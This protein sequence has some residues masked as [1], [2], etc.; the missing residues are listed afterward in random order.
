M[1][2]S[3]GSPAV[4]S[5]L[6]SRLAALWAPGSGGPVCAGGAVWA[7]P[8]GAVCPLAGAAGDAGCSAAGGAEKAPGGPPDAAAAA[9]GAVARVQ[10][11][12][13]AKAPVRIWSAP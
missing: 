12:A 13:A 10:K 6:P 4:S 11:A 7:V 9:A 1:G 8:G 3:P 2:V 5:G